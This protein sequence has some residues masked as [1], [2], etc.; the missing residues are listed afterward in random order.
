MDLSQLLQHCEPLTHAERTKC[1]VELGRHSKTEAFARELIGRL[2]SGSLYEQCLGLETCYGSCEVGPAMRALSLPSRHLKTRC[3]SLIALLGTDTELLEALKAVPLDL[4]IYSLRRL[5]KLRGRRR[6]PRVIDLFLE[7]LQRDPEKSR[8]FQALLPLGSEALVATRLSEVLDRFSMIDWSRLARYHPDVAQ[9]ALRDWATRSED[10]DL[11]LRA[12]ANGILWQW[13][14]VEC[15]ADTA[16]DLLQ[17]MMKSTPLEYLSFQNLLRK[18]PQQVV[19]LLLGTENVV[20]F[21]TRGIVA[22]LSTRQVLALHER[23]PRYPYISQ[24]PFREYTHEQRRAVYEDAKETWRSDVGISP[25]DIVSLLPSDL[26]VKEARRHMYLRHFE[27][28]PSDRIPY[29]GLLPWDE[30]V[31]LLKPYIRASNAD[32]RSSALSSQIEAAKF[33]DEHLGDAMQLVLKHRHE[34]DPV[35]G[36]MID[37]LRSIPASRWKENNLEGLAQIVRHALDAGDLSQG[38]LR[39]LL[40]LVAKILSTHPHWAA[41]QL[42]LIMKERDF[43]ETPGL[44]RLTGAV[45]VNVTMR[46]VAETMSPMLETLLESKSTQILSSLAQDFNHYTKHWPELLDALEKSIDPREMGEEHDILLLKEHWPRSWVRV[47]P[48]LIERKSKILGS[49]LVLEHIHRHQQ[50]YLAFYLNESDG[51]TN[52]RPNSTF[53]QGANALSSLDKGFWRWTS[54]QQEQFARIL[55]KD[56]ND[57]NVGAGRKQTCIKQLGILHFVDSRIR[58]LVRLSNDESP[59]VREAALRA[60]S[61]LDGDQGVSVLIDALQ[62]DRARIAIYALRRIFKSMSK[63]EVFHVLQSAPMGKVTVA[64]EVVRL[65]GEL[66]TEEAFRYLLAKE[67]TQLHP[68]VRIALFRALWSYLERG[69]TWEV[70]RRAATDPDPET[71]KAISTIPDKA[72]STKARQSLLKVLAMLLHHPAAEGRLAALGCCDTIPLQDPE[73]FL[74][75]RLFQLL[76]SPL[77]A[78]ATLAAR[79]VFKIYGK[80]Q[81]E[82]IGDAFQQVIGNHQMLQSHVE[83]YLSVA[84]VYPDKNMLPATLKIL[85]VLKENKLTI[86]LRLKVIFRCLPW[87]ELRAHLLEI[88]PELHAD[89]LVEAEGLMRDSLRQRTAQLSTGLEL[90]LKGNEDE[91]ARRLALVCLLATVAGAGKWTDEQRSRLER[92]RQDSSVLVAE[93]A[94]YVFPPEE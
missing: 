24:P 89:A 63:S 48:R 57:T 39:E 26:R 3:L 74:L 55:I 27:T 19:E 60:L 50:N 64:K 69:E 18:R 36:V 85:S 77:Q 93:A 76:S 61:S 42:A 16:L 62:D 82:R 4:Q 72:M 30:A 88:I 37:A 59:I 90:Q 5:R 2:L 51:R 86:S 45:P 22:K 66:E 13:G 78:E 83:T 34:P 9:T 17:T 40:D 58:N 73:N 7:D 68:D 53:S 75:V 44:V 23:Y 33:D 28:K 43:I 65:I 71:A 80:T 31:E 92:Y 79:T 21:C 81:H 8:T 14:A 11:G 29:L 52:A 91:R 87:D 70:F 15:T 47:I 35:R 6:R 12:I 41:H 84:S 56:I 1:M 32:V 25:F 67:K 46:I 54:N 10:G 49:Y 94:A 20:S 38:N